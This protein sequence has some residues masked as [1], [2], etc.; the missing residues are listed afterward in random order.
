MTGTCICGAARITVQKKPAFIH[1]CDCT[2][3]RKSGAG[4]AY[5]PL[6]EVHTEGQTVS[7]MRTDKADPAVQVHSCPTCAAT[8]HFVAAKSFTDRHGPTDVIGVNMR[9]FDPGDL[10]GVEVRFPDGRGW[11]GQGAFGYRRHPG[12]IGKDFAW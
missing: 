12:V 6:N 2:L 11:S 7:V 10:K 4:W 1:D 8:T 9:L 5:Y 3:C